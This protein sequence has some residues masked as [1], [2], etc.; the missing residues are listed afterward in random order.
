MDFIFGGNTGIQSPEA[1]AKRRDLARA[2]QA[3]NATSMPKNL[4]EGLGSVADAI[5]ARIENSRLDK[6]EAEGKASAE[7]AYA[8]IT[9]ALVN[10]AMPSGDALNEASSNPWLNDTQQDLVKTLFKKQYG[11]DGQTKFGLN[12]V[13]GKDAQGNSVLFQL[14][15]DGSDPQQVKFPNGVVP[16][17]T[18]SYQNLGTSIVG[19]DTKT[20]GKVV[21]MPI[22]V[23]GKAT[24]DEVGTAKGKSIAS[25]PADYQA[26]QNALDLVNSIRN[27]PYKERGT[28]FSS[29]FNAVP[30]TG[31]FDFANKV[32]QAKS[33]A[34]LTAIQQMRGLGALSNA[35]GGAATAAVTRMNTATSEEEFDAAL[36]DYEKI[37]AQGM[38]RSKKLL[39]Q[40]TVP[41]P[42]EGGNSFSNDP[43][44]G[45]VV[46]GFKIGATATNKQTGETLTWDGNGWRP[47]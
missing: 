17:P 25:A 22:D 20:G 30:G 14:P 6:A 27:D 41:T 39:P 36:N 29:I 40:A 8:P 34:F 16:T 43:Q 47:Q 10:K 18:L 26:A 24:Q 42:A 46:N 33:G 7:A 32:N 2:I 37:V 1:L 13:W 35:E 12:P 11:L 31:G 45:Q 28:G 3:R 5:G 21:E 4:W 9:E 19:V 15:Q 38:E 23:A 44:F